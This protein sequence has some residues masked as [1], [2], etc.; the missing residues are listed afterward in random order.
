MCVSH[1]IHRPPSAQHTELLENWIFTQ[2]KEREIPSTL[3]FVF[4]P[5]QDRKSLDI[6][7][8]SEM[9]SLEWIP[10]GNDKI[11]CSAQIN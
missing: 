9:D 2:E 4:I 11:I 8:S 7:F 5:E 10:S 1:A 3:T 6:M